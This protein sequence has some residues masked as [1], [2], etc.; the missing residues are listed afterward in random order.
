MICEDMADLLVAEQC[1]G[2]IARAAMRD[3]RR[4]ALDSANRPAVS[5]RAEHET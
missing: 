3:R 1:I 5:R 2:E 4:D